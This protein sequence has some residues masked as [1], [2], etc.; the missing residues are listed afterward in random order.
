MFDLR[1]S[2]SIDLSMDSTANPGAWQ[3]HSEEDIIALDISD[4]NN[5]HGNE[6]IKLDNRLIKFISLRTLRA[7]HSSIAVIDWDNVLSRF[8]E[9]VILDLSGNK[10]TAA[11]IE[12]LPLALRE[13]DL[14]NNKITSLIGK[15]DAVDEVAQPVVVLPGLIRLDVSNN[16]LTEL[17]HHIEVTSLQTFCFGNN[18]VADLSSTDLIMHCQN[19]L[20]T[21]EGPNNKLHNL[22]DLCCCPKLT[23]ID[24]ADN[25]IDHVPTI[26]CGVIRLNLDNNNITSISGMFGGA[27]QDSPYRSNLME[28]R[29]RGNK[30]SDL[31]KDILRCLKSATFI[32]VGQNELR[33]VPEVFGDLLQLRRLSLD[34]NPIRV[35]RMPLLNDTSALKMFLRKRGPLTPRDDDASA[36]ITPHPTGNQSKTLVNSALIEGCALDLS[37][38]RLTKLPTEIGNELLLSVSQDTFVGEGIRKLN[39]SRNALKDL[40]DWLSAMPNITSLDVSHN[41]IEELPCFVCDIPIVELRMAMNRFSSMNLARSLSKCLEDGPSSFVTSI[42]YIDLAGN[43]LEWLPTALAKLRALSTLILGHNKVTTLA[44]EERDGGMNSGWPQ[45]GFDSLETLDLSNNKISN[46]A[47]FPF[48]LKECCP[49]I[50]RLNLANNE[51]SVIP[52]ALGLIHNLTNI[53]LRGNPQRAIRMNVL[54]SKASEILAYLRSKIDEKSLDLMQS[55]TSRNARNEHAGIC[56]THNESARIDELKE[57]IQDITLQ[58]NNVHLTEAQKYEMKAMLQSK[59]ATLIEEE[60]MLRIKAKCSA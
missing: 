57:S 10:L 35:I 9:L 12:F 19:S 4:N 54:N 22:P 18:M 36:I 2:I 50:R 58:L 42:T 6:M 37:N 56:S 38:R 51:L 32:D 23:I 43:N 47:M 14:S 46:L 49:R 16:R 33:D 48:S 45:H 31:D 41:D 24:F 8:N 7:R 53:D 5:D 44:L 1:G 34:G 30:L 11:S 55:A 40:A 27:E 13:L 28:L 25:E 3:S 21:L 17:P 59:K 26:G 52:P 39:V 60:R 20:S 29:L 15:Q